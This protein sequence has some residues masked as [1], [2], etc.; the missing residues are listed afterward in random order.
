MLWYLAS[1]DGQPTR[2]EIGSSSVQKRIMENNKSLLEIR[3]H[4]SDGTLETFIQDDPSIAD[5]IIQNAQPGRLFGLERVVIAGA[6][7][8]TAFV[9]AK[10]IRVDFVRQ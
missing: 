10:L 2:G 5:T 3:I 8:L 6:H 7:S 4:G 9:P 1:V